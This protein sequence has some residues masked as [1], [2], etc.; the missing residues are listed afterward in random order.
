MSSRIY[1]YPS[2]NMFQSPL[3][4][5]WPLLLVAGTVL[6]INTFGDTLRDFLDPQI[7]EMVVSE[8]M[9]MLGGTDEQTID[10]LKSPCKQIGGGITYAPNPHRYRG[11]IESNAGSSEPALLFFRDAID[12]YG[13]ARFLLISAAAASSASFAEAVPSSTFSTALRSCSSLLPSS[14]NTGIALAY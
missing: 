12:V 2:V 4:V 13:L 14:L 6:A 10:F 8:I 3:Y 11:K 1:A 7:A 9:V 5:V